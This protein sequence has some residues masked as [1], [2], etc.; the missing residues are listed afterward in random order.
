[1][2]LSKGVNHYTFKTV[3]ILRN[4]K[5]MCQKYLQKHTQKIKVIHYHR[6]KEHFQK[7]RKQRC[8]W[9]NMN[10]ACDLT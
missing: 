5:A 9:H 2:H 10:L 3:N 4:D 7:L 8:I 6:N 1:M